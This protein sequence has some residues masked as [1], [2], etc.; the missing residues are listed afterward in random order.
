[1]EIEEEMNLNYFLLNKKLIIFHREEIIRRPTEKTNA[2]SELTKSTE[3][4]LRLLKS[5]LIGI[6][7]RFIWG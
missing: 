7:T 3:E 5:L 2:G 1:M 6:T 4:D